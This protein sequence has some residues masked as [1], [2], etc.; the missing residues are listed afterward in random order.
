MPA[1]LHTDHRDSGLRQRL[2]HRARLQQRND[3]TFEVLAIHPRDQIDQ[4][5]LGTTG[6]VETSN[7][8]TDSDRQRSQT[9][10]KTERH[11]VAER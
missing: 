5:A 3:F 8:V 1:D 9:A 2:C 7:Q 4:A 6:F 11:A 10:A